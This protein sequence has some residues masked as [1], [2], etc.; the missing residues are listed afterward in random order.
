MKRLDI[1]LGESGDLY[2]EEAFT[3]AWKNAILHNC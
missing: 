1:Y 3:E 2:D